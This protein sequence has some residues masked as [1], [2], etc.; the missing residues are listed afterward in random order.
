MEIEIE[1]GKGN[2]PPPAGPNPA[3]LFSPHARTPPSLAAHAAHLPRA[4]VALLPPPLTGRPHPSARPPSLPRDHPLS[5]K[6][7]PPVSPFSPSLVTRL[8]ARS[9]P[10]VARPV[11]S[12]LTRSPARFG[13]L[14]PQALCPSRL[15]ATACSS[16]PVT[17]VCHH[18]RRGK[19]H[20]CSPPLLPGRL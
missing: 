19:C 20:W 10:A 18:R 8:S 7:A 16:H 13:A 11:A 6:R 12:P 4:R 2:P 15:V 14:C 3:H 1:K 9:P 17:T 5:G